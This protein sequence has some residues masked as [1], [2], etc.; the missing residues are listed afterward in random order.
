MICARIKSSTFRGIVD[1]I[2]EIVD[3]V[4]MTFTESGIVLQAMDASH[5]CLC[6]LDLNSEGFAEYVCRDAVSVGVPITTMSKIFK[7]STSEDNLCIRIGEG[8]SEADRM[9]LEFSNSCRTSEFQ[10]RLMDI[11]ADYIEVPDLA[12]DCTLRVPTVE[13]Q[14]I[15]RDANIVGD[16]CELRVD[17]SGVVFSASGDMGDASFALVR[18]GEGG[19][20]EDKD[21]FFE[22]EG[23][24]RFS[25]KYL[26][27]FAKAT[28]LCKSLSMKLP[29]GAPLCL[30]YEMGVLERLRYYLA[31]KIE[32]EED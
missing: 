19:E 23:R 21:V 13:F 25:T 32:D 14:K 17:E 20:D 27:L 11:D 28:P 6:F 7:C 4:V 30:E 10:M 15:V 24:G 29:D 18:K 8:N 5:V 1:A 3:A 26:Q 12:C 31:P 16:T 2:S 22:G 9:T